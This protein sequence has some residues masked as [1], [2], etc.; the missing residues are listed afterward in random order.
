MSVLLAALSLGLFN[1]SKDD[2]ARQFA[3]VYAFISIC[4]LVSTLLM[5]RIHPSDLPFADLWLLPLSIPHQHDSSSGP[6]ALW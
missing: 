3:Y 4:V 1:A 6:R 5:N 2:I